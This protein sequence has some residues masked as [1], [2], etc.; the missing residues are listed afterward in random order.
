MSKTVGQL[1]TLDKN[2]VLQAKREIVNLKKRL[3]D[4]EKNLKAK[5]SLMVPL[6]KV[7]GKYIQQE[8][9]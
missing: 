1:E 2:N 9:K 7:S 5:P 8:I 3:V 4:C 6:G